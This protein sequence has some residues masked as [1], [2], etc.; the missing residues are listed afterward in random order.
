MQPAVR[1]CV[2]SSKRAQTAKGSRHCNITEFFKKWY[3]ERVLHDLQRAKIL[4]QEKKIV[5][6][7]LLEAETKLQVA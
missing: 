4:E 1:A 7:P 2:L 3:W 6:K 5:M